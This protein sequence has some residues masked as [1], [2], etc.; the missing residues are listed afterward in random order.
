VLLCFLLSAQKGFP[1][2]F[3]QISLRFNH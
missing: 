1:S 3:H 2:V